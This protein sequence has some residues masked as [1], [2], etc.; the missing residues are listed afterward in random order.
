MSTL[1]FALGLAAA[2]VLIVAAVS[3]GAYSTVFRG[4]FDAEFS[5]WAWDMLTVFYRFSGIPAAVFFGIGTVSFLVAAA[6]P[7]QRAGF[8]LK[9]RLAVTV[10][11]S[12]VPL[13][14][15]PMYAFMTVNERI[16]LD[17]YVLWL[18]CGE[19]LLLR[20]PI[21]IEYG[22]RVR[23]NRRTFVTEK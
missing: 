19:A 20:T 11:F 7:K 14:L 13:V 16:P 4:G 18:G 9:L 2:G 5:E 3:L 23:E 17:A 1:I 8:P 6:D 21:L 10:V 12:L 22:R 15:A